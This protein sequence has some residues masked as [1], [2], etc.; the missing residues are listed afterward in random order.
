M[1]LGGLRYLLP[2]IE[3]AHRMGIYVVTADYLPNNIAHKYSDEYCNVSIIDKEAVLYEAQRLQ[4]DGILSHAVDPG[5]VSSAYVAEQMGLPFQCDYEVASILQNKD[6]FRAFL[7]EHGFNVPKAKG[8]TSNN[9]QEALNDIDFFNWPVIVKPVDSAGSKGVTKVEDKVKL[10]E[11]IETALNASLS[12]HFIIE[13]F[14]DIDGYQSS[15]DIFTIDG[16]LVYPAYSDQLFDKD[17]PNP[18]TPAIE[19]WP[20]SMNRQHQHELTSEL[21]RLFTLLKVKSGIWNVES[22]VCTNSKAYIMEVSPRGGGNRIAELQDLATGQSLIHNEIKKA[23][24]M[25]LDNLEAP[26]YNG[27]WCNLIVHTNRY[28]IL[29]EVKIDDNF[30]RQHVM[31]IGLTKQAGDI[32]EPFMGANNSLGTLF[33]RFDSRQE[34]EKAL[35]SQ[36]EWIQILLK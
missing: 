23:L 7:T 13:D 12:K 26:Q 36:D 28:G 33:L 8:Y 17:A 1:L 31:N 35:I 20:S 27:V 11:A 19:I 6:R 16:E 25:P 32:V 3:E 9:W 29:K 30:A 22:R 5:V 10:K 2:I 15:A 24:G 18:Y 14:L 4:I 34:L 21:Q